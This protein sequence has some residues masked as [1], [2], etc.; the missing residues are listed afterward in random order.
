MT[1]PERGQ[2]K[3]R[4][5]SRSDCWREAGSSVAKAKQLLERYNYDP[6]RPPELAPNPGLEAD[7]ERMLREL[8]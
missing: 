6:E 5:R 7:W 8:K 2:M 1:I 3:G 4:R